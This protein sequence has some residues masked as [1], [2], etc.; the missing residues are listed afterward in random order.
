MFY[1]RKLAFFLNKEKKLFSN[2]P[3]SIKFRNTSR[4]MTLQKLI[5]IKIL[6]NVKCI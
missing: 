4:K 6:E 5:V 1:F 2:D 3:I